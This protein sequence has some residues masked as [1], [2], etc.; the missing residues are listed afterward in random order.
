MSTSSCFES[1]IIHRHPSNWKFTKVTAMTMRCILLFSLWILSLGSF[2]SDAVEIDAKT[3]QDLI[4][5]KSSLVVID[6]RP[7]SERYY[8]YIDGSV[9]LPDTFT[10]RQSLSK[11]I[12]AKDT[13][14]V[15]YCGGRGGG[16]RSE[17]AAKKALSAGYTNVYWFKGGIKAWKEEHFPLMVN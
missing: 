13:P 9:S 11:L 17:A 14:I 4:D 12:A 1:D 10:T 5:N 15:F 8:G 3:A 7:R 16:L 6:A 2:A